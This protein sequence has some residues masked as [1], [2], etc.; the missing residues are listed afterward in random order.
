MVDDEVV[1]VEH[2]VWFETVYGMG[3][4][5]CR[6]DVLIFHVAAILFRW[7]NES[8]TIREMTR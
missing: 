2:R 7:M 1:E 4:F 3:C 5:H 6:D 8:C